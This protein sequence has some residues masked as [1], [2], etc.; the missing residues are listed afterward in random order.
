M[1]GFIDDTETVGLTHVADLDGAIWQAFGVYAQPAF[2]FINDDGA[3]EVFVGGLD[4]DALA[5]RLDEL[6]A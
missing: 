3:I 6:T 2:A 1:Q 4:E 5:E